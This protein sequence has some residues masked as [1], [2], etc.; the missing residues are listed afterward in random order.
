L[1]A[2]DPTDP[3]ASRIS[4]RVLVVDDNADSAES[5]AMLL[6]L[7][8][9]VVETALDGESALDIAERF[10]PD[11]IL[12]DLGMPKINGYEVC[13]QVRRRA[14]GRD[15]LVIAQTGWGQSQDR[16]RSAA[17]GFDAHLT[18]PVDPDA[19]QEMLTNLKPA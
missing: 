5:M 7:Q 18:K 9:N 12:L 6:R 11:A 2:S 15:V 16:A 10:R 13:E 14:W 19:V 3:A 17:A 4:R 8:G 1:P